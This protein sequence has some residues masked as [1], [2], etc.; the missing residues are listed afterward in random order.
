MVREMY[1]KCIN[2]AFLESRVIFEALTYALKSTCV[3]DYIAEK[4]I[5]RQS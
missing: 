4:V 5:L 3:D 1:F 2:V